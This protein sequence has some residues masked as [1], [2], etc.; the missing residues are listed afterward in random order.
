MTDP[1]VTFVEEHTSGLARDRA[2]AVDQLASEPGLVV[3]EGLRNLTETVL[4]PDVGPDRTHES[5]EVLYAVASETDVR[6]GDVPVTLFDPTVDV[7][8]RARMLIGTVANALETDYVRLAEKLEH[9]TP[10]E[11]RGAAGYYAFLGQS[12]GTREF[13]LPYVDRTRDVLE[14]LLPLTDADD[15]T[16]RRA[17]LRAV[18]QRAQGLD[19]NSLFA[20]EDY[21][22][23]VLDAMDDGDPVVRREATLAALWMTVVRDYGGPEAG[24]RAVES[25]CAL[26]T[27]ETTRAYAEVAFDRVGG[28]AFEYVPEPETVAFLDAVAGRDNDE[29]PLDKVIHRWMTEEPDRMRQYVDELVAAVRSGDAAAV[30]DAVD[31]LHSLAVGLRDAYMRPIDSHAQAKTSVL[32]PAIDPLRERLPELDQVSREKAETYL[33]VAA[34][35]TAED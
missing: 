21:V 17:A 32:E 10:A 3:R 13:I 20:S 12:G 6:V 29:A 15:V 31:S 26:D 2:D 22:D 23:R 18:R 28:D 16:V 35:V 8:R 5:L 27:D 34:E 4:D 14:A 9:G 1:L 24:R 30:C 11:R 33:D 19:V 25:L 7:D